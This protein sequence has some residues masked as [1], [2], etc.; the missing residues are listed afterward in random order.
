VF[1]CGDRESAEYFLPKNIAITD[2]LSSAD[3]YIGINDPP[4]RDH[5]DNP[6]K[7]IFSVKREGVTLSYVLDVRTSEKVLD[8]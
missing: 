5:F 2:R 4:C 7:A 1:V 8:Q 3:F 6:K